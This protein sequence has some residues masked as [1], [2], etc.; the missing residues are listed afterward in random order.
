MLELWESQ[1]A[2]AVKVAL[3]E[4]RAEQ[5]RLIRDGLDAH[6]LCRRV[7]ELTAIVDLCEECLAH[8]D[9]HGFSGWVEETPLPS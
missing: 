6:G 3:V 2:R 9:P 8:I 4:T 7:D 1:A 5:E